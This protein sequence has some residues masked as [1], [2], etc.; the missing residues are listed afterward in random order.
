M[1]DRRASLSADRVLI[2]AKESERM[3]HGARLNRSATGN[4][5]NLAHKRVNGASP[6]ENTHLW[7]KTQHAQNLP[8]C[9]A[10]EREANRAKERN[11]RH[12]PPKTP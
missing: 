3:P 10:L 12:S 1:D 8:T 11:T 4:G 9:G 6:T 2:A 7:Q 5:S